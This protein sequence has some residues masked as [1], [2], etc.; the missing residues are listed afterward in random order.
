ME[1]ARNTL[2]P[3]TITAF[4]VIAIVRWL[5]WFWMVGVVAVSARD[6]AVRQPAVAWLAVAAVLAAAIFATDALRR[7]PSVLATPWYAAS[8]AALAIGLSI[9]D[10]WVFEPGHVFE[11]SQSL[12]TQYPLIAVASIGFAVGPWVAASVGALV[13]PAEWW[14]VRLN[15]F[16][17]L[18]PRHVVSLVGTSIYFA[19]AG[20]VFG[21]LAGLLRRAETEIAEQR[22]RN[23]V[24]RVL[25]DTV[26]QVFAMVERR[27]AATDPELAGSVR[28]ADRELRRFLF[29]GPA[30]T[31]DTLEAA[32][33][34]R[35]DEHT[36]DG[37][38]LVTFNVVYDGREP[39]PDRAQAVVGAI[40]EA[41]ANAVEHADAT[42]L[43][44][45]V[46]VEP[47][48]HVFASVRDDGVGF[49]PDIVDGH[50][51]RHSIIGRIADIG[52]RTDVVTDIGAGTEI[53]L[54]TS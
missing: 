23:E 4:R 21:W 8:E 20:A 13:G 50:G 19:A 43:T 40:G 49:D 30:T 32:L 46:E 18:E 29:D 53:R 15:D 16:G 31:P 33:R 42:A 48:G 22:A 5:V 3:T 9:V 1:A 45:F 38:L 14:A 34:R 27:T 28:R 26:L 54:W 6:D 51:L 11:T 24:A 2:V 52:G 10:G 47:D 41:V 37:A 44:V 12:A 36:A 35:I 39:P 17:V 25:H 7:D